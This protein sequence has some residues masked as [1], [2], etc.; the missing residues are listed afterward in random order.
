MGTCTCGGCCHCLRKVRRRAP[1]E[2]KGGAAVVPLLQ[3]SVPSAVEEEEQRAG[4]PYGSQ[5]A[6]QRSGRRRATEALWSVSEEYS[7][8]RAT[9]GIVLE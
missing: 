8:R 6:V 5:R 7:V 3:L 9:E 2:W 1:K 4:G